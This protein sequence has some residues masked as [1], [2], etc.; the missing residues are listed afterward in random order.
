MFK[1]GRTFF[2]VDRILYLRGEY[3]WVKVQL[4]SRDM[5]QLYAADMLGLMR[6]F[7]E[8]YKEQFL[9]LF[10]NNNSVFVA[11][12][13]FIDSVRPHDHRA[14]FEFYLRDLKK[15]VYL[16]VNQSESA[17]ILNEIDV[18]MN[19]EEILAEDYKRIEVDCAAAKQTK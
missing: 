11:Q 1:I 7:G 2:K 18:Q 8:K 5:I 19:R 16:T 15:P 4:H 13:K 17:R 6:K 14:L 9:V 3:N 12:K 10:N